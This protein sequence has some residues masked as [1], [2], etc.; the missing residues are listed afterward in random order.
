M[1]IYIYGQLKKVLQKKYKFIYEYK[2]TA[3]FSISSSP[4]NIMRRF[5]FSCACFR[6]IKILMPIACLIYIHHSQSALSYLSLRT[7]P[8]NLPS[9]IIRSL[10]S[11]VLVSHQFPQFKALLLSFESIPNLHFFIIMRHQ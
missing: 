11:L 7:M 5:S 8:S 10:S 1:R 9:R 3:P 6:N 2:K 4:D